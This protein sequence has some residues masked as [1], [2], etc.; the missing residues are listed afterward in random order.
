MP[1]T[2]SIER[3]R[4]SIEGTRETMNAYLQALVTR[5]DYGRYLAEDVLWTTVGTD[6]IV[7]GR[8]AVEGLIRAFH[9]RAFDAHPRIKATLFGAGQAALEADFVGTHTGDFLGV[10]ASGRAVDV[11]YVVMYDIQDDKITAL[12][13][14]APMDQFLKQI[15]GGATT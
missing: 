12:R 15:G 9:E 3:T 7:R 11:P 5:G 1:D 2:M 8:T 4:G 10:P 14:Y 6:Q 13:F